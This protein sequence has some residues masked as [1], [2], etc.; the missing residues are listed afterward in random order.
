M[1]VPHTK[2]ALA[3]MRVIGGDRDTNLARALHWIDHA[4]KAGA[5]VIILPEC[6]DLGWTHSSSINLAEP[7]PDG[8]TCQ[9]LIDAANEYKIH[10]CAGITERSDGDIHNAAVLIAPSGEILSSHRKINELDFAKE[11]YITGDKLH[12]AETEFGRIGLMICADGFAKGQ[13]LSRSLGMM[14]AD[15][16]FSPCAWAVTANHNQAKE[17]YGDLWRD[18]YIPVAKEYS[19]WI[20]GVS[21]VGPINEGPWEGRKCIGCSLVIDPEGNEVLQGPY[22][23][24]AEELMLVTIPR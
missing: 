18:N 3:Q 7:V 10:I 16:I 19:T 13:A 1:T 11:F 8:T 14:G 20:F 2:I 6:M 15:M 17:P 9:V 12:V 22:G 21:N 5:N 23:E 4:A 24:N